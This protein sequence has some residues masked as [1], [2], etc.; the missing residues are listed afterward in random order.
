M[1]IRAKRVFR[2]S[3]TT[4]LSLAAAYGIALDMPF[5]APLFGFILAAAPKPP[6][7]LKGY[8]GLLL[9]LSI[10]LGIGLLLIPVLIH[11]PSVALMLVL[12]GLFFANYMS[13]NLGKGAVG[14][15]LTV[16]VALI[17]AAGLMGFEVAVSLI[18]SL[19]ISIGVALLCQWIVYPFFPEDEV[20][21]SPKP[22]VPQEQSSWLA[23]RATLIVF[24]SF[25]LGLINPSFYLPIVMKAVSLG[26]QTSVTNARHAGMELLGST[27]MGG[28]FAALFWVSLSIL[29]NLWMFFL[30]TLLFCIFISTKLYGIFPSRYTP[31]F[32]QNVMIT[33]LILL[34]PAVADSASGKDVYKA[35]FVRISLFIVVTLYAWLALV[36]LD[37]LYNRKKK[38]HLPLATE[39]IA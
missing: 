38:S 39:D 35:F 9:V 8:V 18:S 11:Y 10:T 30:W 3:L 20:L 33:M 1:D 22:D 19:M 17:S 29:P 34:G 31:A 36:T 23:F 26:Q 25:I 6:M 32:W 14:S 13:I 2:L 4:A 24:P 37:W 15:L 16:G 21:T 28:I 7:K 27:I 5:I 12:L